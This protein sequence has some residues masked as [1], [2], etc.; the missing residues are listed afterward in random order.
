MPPSPLGEGP[1]V[2]FLPPPSLTFPAKRCPTK[3][4]NG[5]R[6]EGFPAKPPI[7]DRIPAGEERL[8]IHWRSPSSRQTAIIS[9]CAAGPYLDFQYTSMSTPSRSTVLFPT[10]I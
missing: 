2:R 10:R 4:Q 8:W 3:P 7:G 5:A 6:V 9:G 1:G